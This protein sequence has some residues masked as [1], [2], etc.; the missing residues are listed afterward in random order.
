MLVAAQRT[1]RSF[2]ET[3]LLYNV[4]ASGLLLSRLRYTCC[5]AFAFTGR[6]RKHFFDPLLLTLIPK[7][8]RPNCMIVSMRSENNKVVESSTT[9]FNII[10]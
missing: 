5:N 2:N 8:F 9:L 4:M 3:V 7:L 1:A 10:F 6:K